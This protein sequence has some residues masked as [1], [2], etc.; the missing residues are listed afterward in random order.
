M[1][2]LIIRASLSKSTGGSLGSQ[3]AFST[4]III[5]T[6]MSILDSISNFG[7]RYKKKSFR[8]SLHHI[9]MTYFADFFFHALIIC[10]R[11]MEHIDKKIEFTAKTSFMAMANPSVMLLTRSC[12]KMWRKEPQK[13][14]LPIKETNS[15]LSYPIKRYRRKKLIKKSSDD[16]RAKTS[17]MKHC[18][19]V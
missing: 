4:T 13:I 5:N 10:F 19:S 6:S 15:I 16:C 1:E 17:D 2:S 3:I 7:T 11:F 9:T 12:K 8:D 14:Q 18:V